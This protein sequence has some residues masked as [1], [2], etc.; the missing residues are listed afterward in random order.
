MEN[1]QPIERFRAGQVTCRLFQNEVVMDR[2]PRPMVGATL[3]RR[4]QDRNAQRKTSQ[5]FSRNEI[6]LAIYV[7]QKAFAA[8]I[9][10]RPEG[11]EVK[12]E[13]VV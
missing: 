11:E 9:E 3:G 4:Y 8:M 6:P 7:L 13:D 2:Q 10:K 1:Q 5:S 12:H